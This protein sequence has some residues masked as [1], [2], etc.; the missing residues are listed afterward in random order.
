MRVHRSRT[1][2]SRKTHSGSI[3]KDSTQRYKG[4]HQALRCGLLDCSSE[5]GLPADFQ[6]LQWV[7]TGPHELATTPTV[8][9]YFCNQ[10][11]PQARLR[12]LNLGKTDPST[13]P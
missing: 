2:Q 5:L 6:V 4:L 10:K 3:T 9:R 8:L 13:W 11:D 1:V 7:T 12:Q